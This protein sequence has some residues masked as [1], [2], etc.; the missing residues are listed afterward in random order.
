MIW[1]E[2]QTNHNIPLSQ[3]LMQSKALSSTKAERAEE[4]AKETLEAYRE[5]FMKLR[6]RSHFHN[7]KVRSEAAIADAEAIANYPEDLAKIILMKVTTLNNR[8][9]M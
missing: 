7:I 1:I 2:D 4:A 3:S 6:K 5:W 8:F 9:S